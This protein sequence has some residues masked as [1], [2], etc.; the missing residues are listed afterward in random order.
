MSSPI[1]YSAHPLPG[2]MRCARAAGA[3]EISH[4]E[5]AP[6]HIMAGGG[7]SAG[8][9]TGPNRRAGGGGCTGI[10]LG[11]G[12]VSVPLRTGVGSNLRAV[13]H[14]EQRRI[15]LGPGD[16][17]KAVVDYTADG[18]VLDILQGD[19]EIAAEPVLNR[20]ED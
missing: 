2:C 18:R 10:T 17:L 5:I 20:H 4:G 12:A 7:V 11:V 16:L 9:G 8:Q 14:L 19:S 6:I 13:W 1:R 3:S 15:R